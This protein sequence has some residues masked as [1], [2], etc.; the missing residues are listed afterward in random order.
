MTL[1]TCLYMYVCTNTYI[2]IYIL[3]RERSI[4]RIWGRDVGDYRGLCSNLRPAASNAGPKSACRG[5]LAPR[6]KLRLMIEILHDSMYQNIPQHLRNYGII[7]FMYIY[8]YMISCRNYIT[9]SNLGLKFGPLVRGTGFTMRIYAR[10]TLTEGPWFGSQKVAQI[11]GY[12]QGSF[13]WGVHGG[14]EM[15]DYIGPMMGSLGL[16][17]GSV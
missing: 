10:P 11:T 7:V 5:F 15:K 14:S 6:S 8:I 12:V 2:Y 16:C 4:L 17:T 13:K 3:E 9:N 1:F